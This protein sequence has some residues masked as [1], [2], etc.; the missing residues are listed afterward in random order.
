MLAQKIP[1]TQIAHLTGFS[2]SSVHR[3]S[4]RCYVRAKAQRIGSSG[5][6]GDR[7]RLLIAQGKSLSALGGQTIKLE[8]IAPNDFVLLVRY[9][10]AHWFPEAVRAAGIAPFRW[11]DCRH[12]FASRLRQRGVDL[13]TIAELLGHSPKSG[14]AMTKRYAHLAISNLHDAVSL[15][16]NSTTVAPP[17]IPEVRP[18]LSIQ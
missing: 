11:H 9:V 14:F 6:D 13:S 18:E 10:N 8:E 17:P 12:T 4:Q 16:S 15:L 3:H 5:F 7:D 1:M 2:K